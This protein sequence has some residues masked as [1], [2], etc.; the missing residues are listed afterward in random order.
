MREGDGERKNSLRI[1]IVDNFGDDDHFD[2]ESTGP[3]IWYSICTVLC[4]TLF[5][6]CFQTT[7]QGCAIH[8]EHVAF[9]VGKML[10]ILYIISEICITYAITIYLFFDIYRI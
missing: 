6:L 9:Q 4:L 8:I 1:I 10:G 2:T 7:Y 3:V 5:Y